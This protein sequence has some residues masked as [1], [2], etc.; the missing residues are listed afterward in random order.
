MTQI[1]SP[2]RAQSHFQ[3][4]RSRD[5]HVPAGKTVRVFTTSSPLLDGADCGVY[6]SPVVVLRGYETVK[7]SNALNS[8]RQLDG[9]GG[10][11]VGRAVELSADELARMDAYAER[12]G[13]YHRFLAMARG[14]KTGADFEVW[15]YQLRSDASPVEL[16][17]SAT[18]ENR[19]AA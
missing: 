10:F 15:V 11:I 3:L 19:I 4:D 13:D 6:G 17:A 9:I 16:M 12:V 5:D 14:P 8:V 1:M 2:R 18:A 7:G